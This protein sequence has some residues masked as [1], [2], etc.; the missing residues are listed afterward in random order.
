MDTDGG[1]VAA[2]LPSAVGGEGKMHLPFE[3]T[4]TAS[5]W[6]QLILNNVC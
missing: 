5:D 1:Q 3:P 6:V 2:S 4:D